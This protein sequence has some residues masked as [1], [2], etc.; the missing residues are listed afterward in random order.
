MKLVAEDNAFGWRKGELSNLRLC[1]FDEVDRTL[2]IADTKNGDDREIGLSD[3][4]AMLL[5]QAVAG[6]QPADRIIEVTCFHKW[7]G[8]IKED[9]GVPTVL[10]HDWRRTSAHQAAAGVDENT[11]M[12]N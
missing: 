4:L 5:Q 10:F 7:W 12:P 1:T 6:K 11:I 2:R 9:A 8:R 3:R